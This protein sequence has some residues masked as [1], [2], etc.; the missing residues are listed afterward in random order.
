MFPSFLSISLSH[1]LKPGAGEHLVAASYS[2][3]QPALVILAVVDQEVIFGAFA[4]FR[5]AEV[6]LWLVA[7]TKKNLRIEK[8]SDRAVNSFT[9]INQQCSSKD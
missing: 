2:A 5:M 8:V 7:L 9:T 6:L 1:F 4:E 3:Q